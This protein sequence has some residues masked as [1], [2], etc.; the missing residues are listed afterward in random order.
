MNRS[1]SLII[2]TL[3]A[4]AGCKKEEASGVEVV[5]NTTRDDVTLAAE[6]NGASAGRPGIVLLH[7]IPPQWSRHDWPDEFLEQ[8]NAHDYHVLP[9]DRRGAGDSGGVAEDAYEGEAGR[10]DVEA[11]VEFLIANGATEVGILA[12]SNGTTSLVDYTV[13]ASGEGLPEPAAAAYLTGGSYTENQT[14][15]EEVAAR[16]VPSTFAF[17]TDEREW[18]VEQEALDPG[19]WSWLEY[20]DG[21]H[22]TRMFD[23]APEVAD[24]LDAFFVE[25][26][27]E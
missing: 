7:M 22:G 21:A 19:V 27:G 15:M 14:D 2:A 11:S 20:P 10:Y 16:S 17:S 12:A 6:Y 3:V 25:Q 8:L 23:A 1:S 13:W 18:S 26:L 24:D 5:S 9:I 4:V